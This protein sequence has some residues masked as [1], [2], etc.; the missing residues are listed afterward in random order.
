MQAG[1]KPVETPII[2]MPLTKSGKKILKNFER[3]YGVKRG[4]AFFYG[5]ENKHP[6]IRKKRRK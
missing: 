1:S 4:K 3:E 2:I 5:W 6:F